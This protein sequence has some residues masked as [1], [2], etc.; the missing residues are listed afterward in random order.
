MLKNRRAFLKAATAAG[1]TPFL[2]VA[3]T[4]AE[5]KTGGDVPFAPPASGTT[6]PT[7]PLV[8]FPE[9]RELILLTDRPPNLESPISYFKDDITP[10]DAFFVRWHLGIIPTRIDTLGYR[11]KVGGHVEHELNLSLDELKKNFEPASVIAVNQCSGNGRSL[12]EPRV[13]G[14]QWGNGAVGNAKWTGVRLGDLLKKAG[15][16]AGAVDVTFGGLDKAPM[17]TVQPF[18]KSMPVNHEKIADVIVAYAMNDQPLPM[19]NGFPLR[20]VVP[21]W[22]ATYWV[23]ALNEIN[24]T[25][26]AFKGFWMAK[27]YRVPPNPGVQETPAELAKD[28]IPISAMT[29]RSIFVNPRNEQDIKSHSEIEIEGLA[30]DSGK[31]ISKVE[32][33][34]NAGRTWKDAI[35]DKEIGKYSWRRFR[36][37]WTPA[38]AGHHV[39]M[40]RATNA[41]GETQQTTQWN[42][43]GYAR[44]VIEA[45][46][47]VAF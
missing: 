27:A 22:F 14:G 31:G 40:C 12:F 1:V 43:S 3:C 47:V 9:K 34:V 11:L 20:L 23:K 44:N 16:K 8:K 19:L 4:A 7:L 18:V 29:C 37:K 17:P 15:I 5:P 32:I 39:L 2:P 35:L 42:R 33:S 13:P 30:W 26:E 10:N 36:F 21:G 24:V 6:R 45:V 38:T 41:A 28:T 46:T 25:D